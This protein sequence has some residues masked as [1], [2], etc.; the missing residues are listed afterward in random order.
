MLPCVWVQHVL[1]SWVDAY[2]LLL[3]SRCIY[4]YAHGILDCRGLSEGLHAPG[5]TQGKLRQVYTCASESI[6]LLRLDLLTLDYC[7]S[8]ELEFLAF[9]THHPGY[10]NEY[11]AN[12]ITAP[13][14]D[15][16]FHSKHFYKPVNSLLFAFFSGWIQMQPALWSTASSM[17]LEEQ[18]C[19]AVVKGSIVDNPGYWIKVSM[20]RYAPSAFL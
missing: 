11:V 8:R 19:R 18:V 20:S 15:H 2:L 12:F 5:P 6:C 1:V 7:N 10:L 4:N 16:H 17:L 14:M 3:H 13:E 9:R